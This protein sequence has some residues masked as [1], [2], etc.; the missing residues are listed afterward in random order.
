MYEV[1]V[2]RRVKIGGGGSFMLKTWGNEID[3]AKQYV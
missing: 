1:A 3:C 2:I